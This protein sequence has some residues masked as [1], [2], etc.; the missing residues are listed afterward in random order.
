MVVLLDLMGTGCMCCYLLWVL[1]CWFGV[2]LLLAFRLG[3][4]LIVLGIVYCVLYAY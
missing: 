3:L 2:R 4:A 1:R